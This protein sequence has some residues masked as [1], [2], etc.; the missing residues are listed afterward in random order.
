MKL[1][2]LLAPFIVVLPMYF[3]ASQ[4]AFLPVGQG[5]VYHMSSYVQVEQPPVTQ[6]LKQQRTERAK[7]LLDRLYQ[8]PV[9]HQDHVFVQDISHGFIDTL[10]GALSIVTHQQKKIFVGFCSDPQYYLFN[11][12]PRCD[13]QGFVHN[14]KKLGLE[15][16]E[17]AELLVIEYFEKPVVEQGSIKRE[18]V[19]YFYVQPL[20]G[21]LW[22]HTQRWNI[23]IGYL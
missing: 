3:N 13:A 15:D 10:S 19:E 14:V 9:D 1:F 18:D 16:A 20:N 23:L 6:E 7:V 2:E 4:R 17:K 11:C 5:Q 12:K 8:L 22:A 21:S